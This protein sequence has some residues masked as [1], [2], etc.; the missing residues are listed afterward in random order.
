MSLRRLVA[1]PLIAGLVLTAVAAPGVPA[2]ACA[3]MF[4][5]AN[6]NGHIAGAL[7]GGLFGGLLAAALHLKHEREAS[8][9][10]RVDPMDPGISPVPLVM[11][12]AAG[13]L[14]SPLADSTAGHP[15]PARGGVPAGAPER[16]PLLS[17][18]EAQREGL[19]PPRTAS[20]LPA[21]TMIGAGALLLGLFLL[22]ER[23]GRRRSR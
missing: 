17:R 12:S 4:P 11:A 13:T 8:L 15:I 7:G 16:A 2:Q 14:V 21:F 23:K 3:C 9:Q 22:R 18:G 20:L 19:V 10:P 1:A 6:E 5:G